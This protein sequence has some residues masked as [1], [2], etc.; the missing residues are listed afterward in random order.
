[1]TVRPR[2]EPVSSGESQ[3]GKWTFRARHPP[4]AMRS[5]VAGGDGR[6]DRTSGV[7]DHLRRL[8]RARL[9]G[10]ALSWFDEGRSGCDPRRQRH[11]P[12]HALVPE[13]KLAGLLQMIPVGAL[14]EAEFVARAVALLADQQ[15][16]FVTGATWDI[17]GGLFM[18]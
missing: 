11:A 14:G 3:T 4:S 9:G 18:R 7:S 1:M 15:A 5:S 8:R 2:A 10:R 16:S 6:G 12:V 17:N 13:E